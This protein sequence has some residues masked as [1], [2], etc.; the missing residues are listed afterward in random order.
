VQVL[1]Q[2]QGPLRG[3]PSALAYREAPA[4]PQAAAEPAPPLAA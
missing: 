2:L 3:V 1:S 4:E